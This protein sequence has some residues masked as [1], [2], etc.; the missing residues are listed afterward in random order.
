MLAIDQSIARVRAYA[1]AR[2][3]EIPR[4]T[5]A[6]MAGLHWSTLSPLFREDWN[7]TADTLR[8]LEQL[9]PADFREAA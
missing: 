2:E 9:I 6:K 5:L 7:P 8:R 4:S 1:R 3:S